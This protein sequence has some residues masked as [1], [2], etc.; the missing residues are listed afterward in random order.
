M[1][2]FGISL[3]LRLA[4]GRLRGL[5]GLTRRPVTARIAIPISKDSPRPGSIW[6][7]GR[8]CETGM[9]HHPRPRIKGEAGGVRGADRL[10]LARNGAVATIP[11]TMVWPREPALDGNQGNPKIRVRFRSVAMVVLLI[12]AVLLVA[13]ANGA[14]DNAKGVA[15][16]VGSRM[17]ASSPP[18]PGHLH[19][20][21]VAAIPMP[22][23]STNLLG[24]GGGCSRGAL[25]DAYL[26]A[27]G[28][29]PP[30]F[31]CPRLARPPP[32]LALWRGPPTPLPPSSA[33]APL[34]LRPPL[35]HC[36]PRPPSTPLLP[37][38]SL[39]PPPLSRVPP[40]PSPGPRRT[41]FSPL[42]PA[43]ALLCP[44]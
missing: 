31:S 29:A 28:V 26:A 17:A 5:G 33:P 36:P 40:P 10:S 37:S 43:L 1:R 15:T 23:T 38:S 4:S 27:V 3:C 22:C 11:V 14:N 16:L 32:A 12:A 25:T 2:R 34:P 24:F 41:D 9:V 6:G 13:F 42:P 8:P 35:S 39:I 21:R 30:S 18:S 44:R 19:L 7:R 20:P